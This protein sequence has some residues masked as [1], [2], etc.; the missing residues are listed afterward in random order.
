[1]QRVTA[2]TAKKKLFELEMKGLP[3]TVNHLYR[4]SKRGYRYKT[5]MGKLYEDY[6]SLN[7]MN[8]WHGRPAY[9][10]PVELRVKLTAS[11]RR[12]WDIDNRVKALQDGLM[13]GGVIEDDSQVE[14]LHV[15]R[16]YGKQATTYIEIYSLE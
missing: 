6:I 9:D 13:A 5:A 16:E 14:I 10:G 4:T 3:P 12:R 8:I 11:N 15:E 2:E 1:M 7:F